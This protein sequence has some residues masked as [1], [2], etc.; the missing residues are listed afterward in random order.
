MYI[1]IS[2][3]SRKTISSVQ[4]QYT[5]TDDVKSRSWS[6]FKYLNYGVDENA[7]KKKTIQEFCN[8]KKKILSQQKNDKK[9]I[10]IEIKW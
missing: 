7:K 3:M 6:I 4:Q 9:K 8:G 10:K 5:T 2:G 1:E